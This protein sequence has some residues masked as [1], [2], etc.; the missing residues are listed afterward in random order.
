MADQGMR[1]QS[2][3]NYF[4]ARGSGRGASENT[5][6][7]SG[8]GRGRGRGTDNPSQEPESEP[9][10]SGRGNGRGRG[11]GRGRGQSSHGGPPAART[12]RAKIAEEILD[13]IYKEPFSY[14]TPD[15]TTV[16]VRECVRES[17]RRTRYYAP[18]DLPAPQ[19]IEEGLAGRLAGIETEER[20]QRGGPDLVRRH[21]SPEWDVDAMETDGDGGGDGDGDNPPAYKTLDAPARTDFTP[22]HS[23]T[24]YTILERSTVGGAR[25]LG[26]APAG[27]AGGAWH[28][29]TSGNVDEGGHISHTG[30]LNFASAK[31]PGGG[32]VSGAQAQE[33]ALCRASTL[34]A[35]LISERG[36]RFYGYHQRGGGRGRGRGRGRGGRGRGGQPDAESSA[37]SDAP[38]RAQ[39][40]RGVYS[41]SM[42]YTPGVI[43]VRDEWDD[44]AS[45]V[46]VNV[47]TSAAVNAGVVRQQANIE[48]EAEERRVDE[49]ALELH[50]TQL[51]RSR[52]H[53]VL[54]LFLQQGDTKLILG[55]FGTGVFQNRVRT[56]AE[57]WA[58]LLV[59]PGAPFENAFE[60]V[61]FSILGHDTIVEFREVWGGIVGN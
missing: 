31:N 39:L 58:E 30:V 50:I 20:R 48:A 56:I 42:L 59:V 1:Q 55:S 34:Y 19:A 60:A 46:L 47:V 16:H 41:D 11:R 43:M 6:R 14:S 35:S 44:W 3:T 45:P 12:A 40:E 5:S 26:T 37:P 49:V 2:L 53:R 7:G 23:R 32:F 8:R 57:I 54:A 17:A 51:M 15:G 61:E 25:A 4:T 52:M 21:E 18:G 10:S 22:S 13:L 24:T 29:P 36:E 28:V 38:D 27:H 33:E 9:S